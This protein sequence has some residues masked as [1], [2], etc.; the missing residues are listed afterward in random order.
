MRVVILRQPGATLVTDLGRRQLARLD[1]LRFYDIFDVHPP[2]AAL[3][4]PTF[5]QDET[6]VKAA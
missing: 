6:A 3:L 1:A 2:K 4:A 5:L